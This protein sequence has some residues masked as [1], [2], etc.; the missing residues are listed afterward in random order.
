MKITVLEYLCCGG[1]VGLPQETGIE[2]PSESPMRALLF[3]G[4]EMWNGVVLDLFACGHD[5]STV[6]DST[7]RHWIDNESNSQTYQKLGLTDFDLSLSLEDN[8]VKASTGSDRV[9]VI[10]PE[11]DCILVNAINHLRSKKFVVVAPSL[12]F[13]KVASDKWQTFR[14]LGEHIQQP[15]TW[16]ASDVDQIDHNFC[17]AEFGFVLKP[18]DGAGGGGCLKVEN[19]EQLKETVQALE[20]PEQWIVQEWRKGKHCS[21]AMLVDDAGTVRVLGA[22]EQLLRIDAFGFHYLGARG[23][24]AKHET[25]GIETWCQQVLALIPGAF[26]WIGIDFIATDNKSTVAPEREPV[27]RGRSELSC[28]TRTLIEIN[29]RLTTSYL[30]YRQVYG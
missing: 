27:D 22:T 13:L 29:P 21:V 16:L 8:W 3:E 15:R 12:H 2:R 18:R 19:G 23:P 10:A 6:I 30:L 11:I 5:V 24:L 14:A 1:L 9:V 28:S 4:L 26:G 20:N 17:S 7:V 25:E